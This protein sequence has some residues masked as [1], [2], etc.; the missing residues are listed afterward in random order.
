MW[1][2]IV[3]FYAVFVIY[4]QKRGKIV[5]IKKIVSSDGTGMK[6]PKL[7]HGIHTVSEPEKYLKYIS[8]NWLNKK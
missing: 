4:A 6:K 1:I 5:N 7:K 3:F 2:S 8:D